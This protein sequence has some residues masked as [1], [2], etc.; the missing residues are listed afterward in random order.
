MQEFGEGS[1]VRLRHLQRLELGELLV[2]ADGGNDLPKAVE[3]LVQTVHPA[4]L[5]SIRCQPPLPQ[6]VLR[7]RL[8]RGPFPR[9]AG[10]APAVSRRYA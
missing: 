9:P 10:L 8:R 3:G 4:T 2:A 5:P 7:H 6:D 1:D